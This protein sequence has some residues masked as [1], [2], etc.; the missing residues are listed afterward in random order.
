VRR[1]AATSSIPRRDVRRRSLYIGRQEVA[2]PDASAHCQRLERMLAAAPFVQFTGASGE[3]KPGHA[4]VTLTVRPEFL[5]SAG[6]M[7]G[8]MSFFALD[9]AAF[10]AVASLVEDTF[11]LTT[12]LTTYFTRPISAGVVKATGTVVSQT[13]TTFIAEAVLRDE[14]S[15]KE[16]ARAHGL[17]T[18]SRIPLTEVSGYD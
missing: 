15:G 1:R 5:H 13:K 18:R 8:A 2:M 4:T 3:I 14:S 12:S 10:F 17:F 16:I 7:H 6:A 11:V 9:T